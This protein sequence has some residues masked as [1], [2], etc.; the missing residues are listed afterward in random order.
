MTIKL[1]LFKSGEDVIADATEMRVGT[2]EDSQVIGYHL[3]KPC[4]VKMQDPNLLK[5][6]GPRKE[7]GFSVSLFPWIP[8]TAQEV[9]PVPADWLITM[10]EPVENLKE[11]YIKD[12]VE[13]GKDDQSD[14]T[15][16][17]STSPDQ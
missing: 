15:D 3:N 9:I 10:V 16:D 14:S 4:V 6:D 13:Y 5:E 7:S 2:E 1:M 8:L 11:M 12:I 17:D